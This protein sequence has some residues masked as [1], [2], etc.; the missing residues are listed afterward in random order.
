MSGD[1][2]EKKCYHIPFGHCHCMRRVLP[3]E[4]SDPLPRSMLRDLPRSS[5]K[6][7]LVQVGKERQ[8]SQDTSPGS[9]EDG[10]LD[11]LLLCLS[12]A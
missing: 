12:E 1:Q 6:Q 4:V 5:A 7:C 8:P 10:G 3:S 9:R 2:R 11:L